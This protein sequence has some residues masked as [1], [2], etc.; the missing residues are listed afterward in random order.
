MALLFPVLSLSSLFQWCKTCFR[1]SA[2]PLLWSWWGQNS[3]QESFVFIAIL[4]KVVVE[5]Q[6]FPSAKLIPFLH[7]SWDNSL[8]EGE[9]ALQ[10]LRSAFPTA[11]TV[12]GG[13]QSA[14]KCITGQAFVHWSIRDVQRIERDPMASGE[15]GF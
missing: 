13:E 14:S 6:G 10:R 5:I 11:S 1:G 8:T 2:C 3:T 15:L 12:G 4:C 7:C 9:D